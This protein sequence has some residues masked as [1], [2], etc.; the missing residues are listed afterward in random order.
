[1]TRPPS[2]IGVPGHAVAATADRDLEVV[3]ARRAHRG[4]HVGGAAA[5]QDDRRT[6][7]DEPVVDAPDGVVAVVGRQDEGTGDVGAKGGGD[8]LWIGHRDSR[9][10]HSMH[11]RDTTP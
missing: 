5:L 10:W 4:L 1:M 7:V 6:T 11:L 8:R 2:Q 3:L 9:Q